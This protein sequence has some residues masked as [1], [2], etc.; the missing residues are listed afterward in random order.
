MPP[1]PLS[2]AQPD[3]DV[4]LTAKHISTTRPELAT[5]VAHAIALSSLIENLFAAM[6][7]TMLGAQ[8]RPAAAM[9]RSLQSLGLKR[10]AIKAAAEEV[11][12]DHD[13]LDLFTAVVDECD[14]A[15]KHRNRFVHWAW[16]TASV[17]NVDLDALVFIDPKALL[18]HE[19]NARGHMYPNDG[20]G[21]YGDEIDR[22]GV[23]VYRARDLD[24]AV[25]ELER[26]HDYL[27]ALRMLVIPS[28]KAKSVFA[29]SHQRLLNAPPIARRLEKLRSLRKS[30]LGA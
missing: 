28:P 30:D 6:L 9:L 7:T 20:R 13:E 8:A 17:G 11:L 24:E 5:K 25:A 12:T 4:F 21:L 10:A 18:A 26:A 22:S 27:S 23:L 3:A 1:Q 2:K 14:S 16:A 15:S 19:A 29:Q